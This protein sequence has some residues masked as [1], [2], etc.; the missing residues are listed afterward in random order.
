MCGIF[1]YLSFYNDLPFSEDDALR[2]IEAVSHRGPDARIA[3]KINHRLLMAHARLSIL[4]LGNQSNQPFDYEH[5]SLVFNGE[6]YN[7][8]ELRSE[9]VELGFHFRT[10]SDTE[11]IPAA[12]LA[13]GEDCVKRFNGMWAIALFDHRTQTLFCSRDRFGV[14]PFLYHRDE[15]GFSFASEAKSILAFQPALATPNYNSISRFLRETIGAQSPDSWF[16]G[17]HR[18]PPAHNLIIRPD[19]KF[20]V[21]RYWNYPARMETGR[22]LEN[23]LEEFGHLFESSVSLRMRSDVPVG[24]TLSG[25]VD[26]ALIAGVVRKNYPQKLKAYTASFPG[27]PFDEYGIARNLCE[28]LAFESIEVPVPYNN[29]TG[30]LQEIVFH[31][32][33]G[34]GSPAIYPLWFVAQRAK[35]D[36]VVFLEGQGADELLGG[37]VTTL[38]FDQFLGLLENGCY[39]EALH[40]L[41]VH[42]KNWPLFA[43]LLLHLR[44]EIPA[45]AREWFRRLSGYEG[46]FVGELLA[47][48]P[49]AF[50][51]LGLE[52]FETKLLRKSAMMHQTGLVNLLHYG[53][54]IS[55]AHSLENRLPFLD[56]R[57][58]EFAFQLPDSLKVHDGFGKFIQ[59]RY[60][61]GLIPDEIL[62]NPKKLGFVSPLKQV[63]EDSRFGALDVLNS[64]SLTE[65]GFFNQRK[66]SGIIKEHQS[67]RKNH[68]RMLFKILAT[69]LWFRNFID[70]KS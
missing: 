31:L 55:M 16:Q 37:Y 14:K 56:Y 25:G 27:E 32:E 10:G 47:H 45:G 57:L 48:R 17:I 22:T 8:I 59:R 68:E 12:F 2:A 49:Y 43:S 6:I 26:S 3:R 30:I 70:G 35:K 13:W 23:S 65:R 41:K 28:K 46:L 39:S 34:H 36:I 21:D 15:R 24:L 67:G 50:S 33:S 4:D 29:Y 52:R 60:A 20:S 1:G 44:L 64:K 40:E 19:G 61:Q 63:F 69:E 54:A 5:L 7:Y 38:F 18:L 62:H 66:L 11:V 53:D 58:V 9:L 51:E 42:R